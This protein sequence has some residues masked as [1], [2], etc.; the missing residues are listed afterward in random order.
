[1]LNAWKGIRRFKGEA[2]FS[3][4]LYRIAL[5]TAITFYRK[6][7]RQPAT[8]ELPPTLSPPE[9]NPDSMQEEVNALYRAIGELSGIDKALVM[10][11]LEEYS[12]TEISDIMGISTNNVAVKMNRIKTK[13]RESSKK[14]L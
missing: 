7:R 13:L 14:Y 12:Y 6:E 4:W 8:T 11:Y 9:T 3:T 1:M 2:K 5:N 10:L